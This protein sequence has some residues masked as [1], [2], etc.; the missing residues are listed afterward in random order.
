RSGAAASFPQ[1][2]REVS[3]PDTLKEQIAPLFDILALNTKIADADHAVAE[4][5]GTDLRTRR[6]QTFP[7][8]GPV[9]AAAFVSTLDT[10]ERFEKASQVRAFLGLVPKEYSSG[11]ST[12]RGRITKAGNSR[13]RALLVEVAWS[14]LRARSQ[15][16]ARLRGWGT[17]VAAR[18]GKRIAAVAFA[19]GVAGVFFAEWGGGP[20]LAAGALGGRR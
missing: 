17:R 19:L 2:V 1:R 8:V 5:A 6:L 20:G 14:V 18:R 13:L 10:H 11:E 16:A 12:H 15:A 4:H 9:T 3:L 7:G